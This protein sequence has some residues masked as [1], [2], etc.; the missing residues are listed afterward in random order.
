MANGLTYTSIPV[1]QNLCMNMLSFGKPKA[2]IGK[3][4]RECYRVCLLLAVLFYIE[5]SIGCCTVP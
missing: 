3:V 5:N 4:R 1:Q 2:F